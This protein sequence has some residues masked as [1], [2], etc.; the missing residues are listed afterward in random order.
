MG[1]CHCINKGVMVGKERPANSLACKQVPKV[2]EESFFKVSGET[3][4]DTL[5]KAFLRRFGMRAC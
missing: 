3:S 5:W 2:S 4:N 1:N